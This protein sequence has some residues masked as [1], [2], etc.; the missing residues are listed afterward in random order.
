MENH[1]SK[2]HMHPNVHCSTIT[3]ARTWKEPKCASVE[4][5]I[6]MWY[7]YTMAI[8][9]TKE[10][11]WRHLEFVILS[12]VSQT[13]GQITYDM[14]SFICGILKSGKNELIYKA[15]IELQM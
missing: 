1:N 15:E 11:R 7:I 13:E 2:R 4:K 3:I 14:R 5:Q 9:R 10:C 8:K 6:K 12:K